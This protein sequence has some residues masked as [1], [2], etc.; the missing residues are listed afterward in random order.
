MAVYVDTMRVLFR[1]KIM[2]HLLAD[3]HEEL[4]AMARTLGLQDAWLQH[5]G[6]H[7]EHYDVSQS[8]RALAIQ[9]G[10]QEITWKEAGRLMG[11]KRAAL[12]AAAEEEV[13]VPLE[14]GDFTVTPQG[15]ILRFTIAEQQ[16]RTTLTV[17]GAAL[18]AG[19]LLAWV[20][21][22]S[23]STAVHEILES[24]AKKETY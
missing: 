1:G 21:E 20:A 14:V 17:A 3:T 13:E 15:D 16:P 24:S 2:S 5:P 8:K 4:L 12:L 9:H 18:L 10:A 7:R 6:T 22:Q 23:G 11:R 19:W